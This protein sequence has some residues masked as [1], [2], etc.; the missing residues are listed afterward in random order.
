M[1]LL[2]AG[3]MHSNFNA[4]LLVGSGFML[5]NSLDLDPCFGIS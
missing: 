3:S 2:E 5:C 1:E 4:L